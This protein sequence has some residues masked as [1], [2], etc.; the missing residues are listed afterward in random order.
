MMSRGRK[1]K[2]KRR[3]KGQGDV[4][5]LEE[6]F[7]GWVMRNLPRCVGKGN[8]ISRIGLGKKQRLFVLNA[9]G[10][11]DYKQYLQSPLW[12]SIRDKVLSSH[13][14]CACGCGLIADTVHHRT[15]SEENLL[16]KS[17]RGLIAL[18]HECHYQSEFSNGRKVPLNMANGELK[19]RKR[20]AVE[21]RFQETCRKIA[22]EFRARERRIL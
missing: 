18:N 13:R 20:K 15:Y 2:G 8:R 12:K 22:A 19:E 21:E 17:L 9:Y 7:K 3:K 5:Y 10:Y 1:G 16:G 11:Q 4:R 14:F 6:P